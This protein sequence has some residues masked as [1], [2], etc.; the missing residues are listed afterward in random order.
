MLRIRRVSD[1]P[2]DFFAAQNRRELLPL[3]RRRDRERRLVALQRRVEEEPQSVRHDIAGTPRSVTISQQVDEIGLHLVVTNLIGRPPIEP[4]A[5]VLRRTGR[6][7]RA[8]A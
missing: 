4:D 3:A 5:G 6:V 1:H 7:S 8:T 2:L